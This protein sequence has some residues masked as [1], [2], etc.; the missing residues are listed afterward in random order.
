[1]FFESYLMFLI[2][3][4]HHHVVKTSQFAFALYFAQSLVNIRYL[5]NVNS[6]YTSFY[7]SDKFTEFKKKLFLNMDKVNSCY[8]R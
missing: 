1:M 4:L 2:M 6:H 7:C 8:L 3:C 5:E